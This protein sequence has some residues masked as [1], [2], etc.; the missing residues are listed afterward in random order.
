MYQCAILKGYSHE[1]AL[2]R[3]LKK[4]YFV[5]M[6][7]SCFFMPFISTLLTMDSWSVSNIIPPST[8]TKGQKPPRSERKL[9]V[10]GHKEQRQSDE[11]VACQ[12]IK[13]QKNQLQIIQQHL[14]E[15]D[16]DGDGDGGGDGD[17]D[18]DGGG[19]E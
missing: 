18:G 4:L 17:G 6:T 11:W 2:S 10:F 19:G 8:F 5:S 7:S 1:Q 3:T 9:I 13:R 15:G 16:G 12:L 14:V